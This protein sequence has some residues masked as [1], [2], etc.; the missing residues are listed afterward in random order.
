M[1]QTLAKLL[2]HAATALAPIGGLV[3]LVAF[4][5]AIKAGRSRYA[6][7]LVLHQL[8]GECERFHCQ[9]VRHPVVLPARRVRWNATPQSEYPGFCLLH[10]HHDLIQRHIRRFIDQTRQKIGVFLQWRHRSAAR[11][12]FN[13]AGHL[14][15]LC[16]DDHHARAWPKM[17]R[18]LAPRCAPGDRFK[19]TF[20]QVHRVRS[21]H[22]C[23]RTGTNATDMRNLKWLRILSEPRF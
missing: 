12:R 2:V 3:D 20:T 14:V 13:G 10:C 6:K 17:L 19:Y 4:R 18:G 1:P 16:P 21:R 8:I 23:L 7:E 11:R 22:R 5:V 9:P 15:S